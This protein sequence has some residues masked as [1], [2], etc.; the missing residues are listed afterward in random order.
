MEI[1]DEVVIEL[2]N[3][4]RYSI[5][6]QP[7]AYRLTKN[8]RVLCFYFESDLISRKLFQIALEEILGVLQD[9]V[10]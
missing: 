10:K 8:G 3:K 7:D 1:G 5:T 6:R 2:P 4:D 9:L